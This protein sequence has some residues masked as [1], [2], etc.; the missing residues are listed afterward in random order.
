MR[1]SATWVRARADAKVDELRAE[2]RLTKFLLR[3]GMHPS[4]GMRNWSH[5]YFQWLRT[6]E[7][8]HLA[9]RVVFADCPEHALRTVCCGSPARMTWCAPYWVT[10]R[11]SSPVTT[12]QNNLATSG[13]EKIHPRMDCLCRASRLTCQTCRTL[14]F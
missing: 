7:F 5:R 3:L 4:V 14:Q 8:E 13:P 12:Y 2:H 9:D 6:V 10:N 11:R 1:H